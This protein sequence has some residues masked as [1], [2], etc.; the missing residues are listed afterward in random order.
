MFPL[1]FPLI[2]NDCIK[3]F[4][5]T[6]LAW[7]VRHEMKSRKKLPIYAIFVLLPCILLINNLPVNNSFQIIPSSLAPDM[8]NQKE[9]NMQ[10]KIAQDYSYSGIG[11]AWNATHWA[12]TNQTNQFVSFTN[13]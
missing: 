13:G 8:I 3:R 7:R 1:S 12:N 11:T 6:F 5:K 2:K 9:Q 4:S 10:P